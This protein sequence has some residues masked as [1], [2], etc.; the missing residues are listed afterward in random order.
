MDGKE[1]I[2]IVVIGRNEGDR[3]RQCLVAAGRTGQPLVYVDSRSTDGSPGLARSLGV[4]V[5]EIDATGSL[6]A[7][8]ARNEGFRRLSELHPDVGLVQFLD[9]DCELFPG[10]MEEA[11][12]ALG[13][14]QD[15]VA[16][17]GRILER[18][19]R[20]NIYHRLCA[21][22]WEKEPGEISAC[23]GNLMVRARSFHDVGGFRPEVMAAEDDE[24]CL[25]LRR[26]Q[27]KILHLAAD[28]VLHDVA[29]TRFR[30]WWQ[31]ARRAGLAYAQGASLHGDGPERHFVRDCRRIWLWAGALPLLALGLAWPTRGW[32]LALLALYL[33]QIARI[34]RWGRRRGWAAGDASLYAAF[35]VLSK[36]P[37]L[38][39]LVQFHWRRWRGHSP[40]LIEHKEQGGARP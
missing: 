11:A 38:A 14:R 8:R 21:M 29:M 33:V 12:R 1:R 34:Y 25:R 5:V 7:A 4:T 16:V 37:G 13:A 27:G 10:W 17:C 2:G 30:Q 36:F 6:S 15:V 26:S 19:P 9:G 3:L 18:S 20:A 22:E 40:A 35:A 31:R 28:M 32:A 24:L 23:G 39:G